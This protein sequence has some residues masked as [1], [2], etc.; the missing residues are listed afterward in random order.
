MGNRDIWKTCEPA[1]DSKRRLDRGAPCAGEGGCSEKWV[2]IVSVKSKGARS[3]SA[4]GPSGSKMPRNLAG[5][6]ELLDHGAHALVDRTQGFLDR[7]GHGVR[8]AVHF[9]QVAVE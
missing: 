8:P 7:A 1:C 4:P 3:V 9:G 2:C 6:L 5:G